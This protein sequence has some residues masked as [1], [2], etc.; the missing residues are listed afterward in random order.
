MIIT[1]T[2]PEC[3][4]YGFTTVSTDY[5]VTS[6]FCKKCSGTGI[7]D[8]CATH[9]ELLQNAD[10]EELA[11]WL[12]KA[13]YMGCPPLYYSEGQRRDLCISFW[14]EWLEQMGKPE[15]TL[16]TTICCR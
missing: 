2:C 15:D 16:S 9:K 3:N 11:E 6:R 5:S 14:N 1:K 10:T 7:V 8:V 12:A 13:T 4:G